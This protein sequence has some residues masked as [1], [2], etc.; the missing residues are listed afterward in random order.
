[1]DGRALAINEKPFALSFFPGGEGKK[2]KPLVVLS[3]N[4]VQIAALKRSEK[5]NDL[6]IRLFEPTGRD[7]SVSIHLPFCNARKKIQIKGFEIKTVKFNCK[8]RTF[9][10]T[11]LLEK[12]LK[13]S[14]L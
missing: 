7:R 2:P 12:P 3:D 13:N 9:T 5:N 1:V 10:E 14:K 6:I 8:N 11:D 4:I